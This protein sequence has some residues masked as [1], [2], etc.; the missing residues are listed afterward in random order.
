VAG[1]LSFLLVFW[2]TATAETVTFPIIV[3]PFTPNG[4]EVAAYIHDPLLFGTTGVD[5]TNF[6]GGTQAVFGSAPGV[7]QAGGT[8][9]FS[10][11]DLTHGALGVDASGRSDGSG[12]IAFS[13]LVVNV[14]FSG[15][16]SNNVLHFH[17]A[18]SVTSDACA[19]VFCG[20][21]LDAQVGIGDTFTDGRIGGGG[22]A[23]IKICAGGQSDPGCTSGANLPIDLSVPFSVSPDLHKFQLQFF[24]FGLANGFASVNAGNTGLISLDLAPG[25]TLDAGSGFLTEPGD[26]NLGGPAGV[27]EPA[28]AALLTGG[29][30]FVL[31]LFRR[32]AEK[33]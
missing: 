5:F 13:E 24:M 8:P 20:S 12:V 9:G 26:P 23:A 4:Y 22:G 27:P 17:V 1:S 16:G 7:T 6:T 19:N 14:S 18:G 11:S 33:A 10:F 28:T 32:R 3:N 2:G 21:E 15:T 25:V 29:G 30:A 31:C